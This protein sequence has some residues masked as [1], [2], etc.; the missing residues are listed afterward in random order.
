M[1]RGASGWEWKDGTQALESRYSGVGS[2]TAPTQDGTLGHPS[3]G[4]ARYEGSCQIIRARLKGSGAPTGTHPALF[5][6]SDLAV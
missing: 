5:E 2:L 3:A 6:T 4:P 1:R